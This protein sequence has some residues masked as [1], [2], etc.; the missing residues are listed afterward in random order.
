MLHHAYWYAASFFKCPITSFGFSQSIDLLYLD[1]GVYTEEVLL[2]YAP[3]YPAFAVTFR[4]NFLHVTLIVLLQIDE[5]YLRLG[6]AS[7]LLKLARS[8]DSPVTADVYLHLALTMQVSNAHP[9]AL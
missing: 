3:T 1:E 2:V 5:G 4:R 9:D 7:A 8:Q 6:A